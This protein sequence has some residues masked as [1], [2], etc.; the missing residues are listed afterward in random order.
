MAQA[1]ED[2]LGTTNSLEV[3]LLD[4]IVE[5]DDFAVRLGVAVQAVAAL[6][7]ASTGAR[8]ELFDQMQAPQVADLMSVTTQL[9]SMPPMPLGPLYVPTLSLV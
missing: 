4:D 5:S 8:K 3:I 2:T 6:P 1:F 9:F 7:S